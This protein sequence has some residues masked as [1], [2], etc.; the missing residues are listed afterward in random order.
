MIILKRGCAGVGPSEL[1]GIEDANLH[2]VGL[3]IAF[4]LGQSEFAALR[5]NPKGMP[6]ACAGSDMP[7][8][9]GVIS[10]FLV[11]FLQSLICVKSA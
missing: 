9:F 5:L 2:E 3:A 7:D 11:S 1:P 6:K 8:N 4:A 10:M